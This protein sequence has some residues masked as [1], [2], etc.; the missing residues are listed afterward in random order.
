MNALRAV[1]AALAATSTAC[2]FGA[3]LPPGSASGTFFDEPAGRPAWSTTMAARQRALDD[4]ARARVVGDVAVLK[5]LVQS[6][7]S[8]RAELARRA[9]QVAARVD[10]RGAVGPL[11]VE[12][13]RETARWVLELDALLYAMWTTYR[14]YLPYASEPDPYAPARGATMLSAATRAKGGLVALAAE[15]VRMDNAAAVVALLD[16]HPT[17]AQVLNR[18]DEASG[19]PAESY[20]RL[21]GGLLDPDHRAQLQRYVVAAGAARARAL[22]DDQ[23]T[24]WLYAVVGG[25][26]TGRAVVDESSAG[27]T[28]RMVA[29]A[30]TRSALGLASPALAL[31]AE[32]AWGASSSTEAAPAPLAASPDVADGLAAALQ[33]MDVV[34]VRDARRG[35][36]PRGHVHALVHLGD[37]RDVRARAPGHAALAL[38]G[39]D[40][41][42]G[43]VFLV[44]GQT[45][46][47]LVDLDDVLLAEDVAVLR[48]VDASAV[49]DALRR[50]LDVMLDPTFLTPPALDEDEH[51]ARLLA[52][53]LDLSPPPR[54]L[55]DVL[56]AVV[57]A[58][59]A[60][61]VPFAT[62]EGVVAADADARAAA[63]RALV[64]KTAGAR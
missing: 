31:A 53:A 17:V 23:D 32:V 24:A 21:V 13:V 49:D 11:E 39:G 20:D 48:V 45:G 27:R 1:V 59:G 44:V 41:R 22:H 56:A 19:I 63:A 35:D 9:A 50:A 55:R 64:E 38:H 28:V 25:S 8:L 26:E 62:R 14:A 18:G 34:V 43:R 51:A 10:R 54:R 2:A 30:A 57:V 5:D 37:A 42:R 60:T 33:P 4:A 12:L 15:L 61:D 7:T 29:A 52:A 6:S 58:G 36:A 16:A 3:R 47:A 46:P 40:L